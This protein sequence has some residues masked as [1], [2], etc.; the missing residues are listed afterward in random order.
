MSKIS[1]KII[2]KMKTPESPVVLAILDVWGHR[3]E[4]LD[5]AIKKAK[6]PIIDAAYK[7]LY[8]KRDA[9][10]IFKDLSDIIF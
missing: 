7:I 6:T 4:T 3:E 9:K 2:K 1:S 10:K 5:N 8:E